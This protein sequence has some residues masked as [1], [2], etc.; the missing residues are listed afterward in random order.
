MREAIKD[1]VHLMREASKNVVHLM[2][3]AIKDVVHLMRE[4]IKNVVRLMREAIKNV[5]H[6]MREAISMQSATPSRMQSV[7]VYS[8]VDEVA[9]PP[10]NQALGNQ[11][12]SEPT[13][14]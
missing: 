7:S 10:S 11:R 2:R 14:Q 13:I 12:Q 5:V 3:E 4:A 9:S 1:V 8:A 6:L